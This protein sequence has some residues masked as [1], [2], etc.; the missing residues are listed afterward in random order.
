MVEQE[1]HQ[2]VGPGETLYRLAGKC[3]SFEVASDTE[4]TKQQTFRSYVDKVITRTYCVLSA[5]THLEL[6]RRLYDCSWHHFRAPP[7]PPIFSTCCI[8]VDLQ[9]Y[10]CIVKWGLSD[11]Q[12]GAM[13]DVVCR[14]YAHSIAHPWISISSQFTHMVYL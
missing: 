10:D 9:Q 3:D 2:M 6:W 4:Q 1:A 12:V 8:F 5:F 14:G 7:H 11:P 13:G